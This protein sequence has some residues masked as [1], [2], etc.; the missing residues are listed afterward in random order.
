MST[1]SSSPNGAPSVLP[2]ALE[3]FNARASSY[4]ESS[5][6]CSLELTEGLVPLLLPIDSKSVIL[7]NACGTG[8]ATQALLNRLSD[9][10]N[11]KPAIHAVDAAPKMVDIARERFLSHDNVSTQVAKGEDL[12]AF[13]DG[14]FTHSIT[15]AGFFFFQDPHKGAQ[16]LVRTLAD[17]GLA[18]VTGWED[19]GYIEIARSVQRAIR[20]EDKPFDIPLPKEWFDPDHA[21]SIL[22]QEGFSRIEKLTKTCHWSA[23]NMESL[24]TAFVKWFV[25]GIS[26]KWTEDEKNEARELLPAILSRFT[27]EFTRSDGTCVVG[28]PMRAYVLVC[29][30]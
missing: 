9:R 11:S 28:F 20:P 6:G 30:K 10:G 16:E 19:V 2:T 15:I 22:V 29:R 4:D 23:D 25:P 7:D 17:S 5:G 27:E 24:A 21:S 1:K 3:H 12:S 14:M 13:Q 18:I 8:V 26:A